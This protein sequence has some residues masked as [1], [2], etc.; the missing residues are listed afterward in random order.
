[1]KYLTSFASTV[2]LADCLYDTEEAAQICT[3]SELY[4]LY[5][6]N[7]HHSEFYFLN[8]SQINCFFSSHTVSP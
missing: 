3:F 6:F 4:V 7:N 2:C 8:G 1:M 5:S